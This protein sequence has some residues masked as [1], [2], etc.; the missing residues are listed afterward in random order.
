MRFNIT[1]FVFFICFGVSTYPA[2]SDHGKN[3]HCSSF[4]FRSDQAKA[5]MKTIPKGKHM[6]GIVSELAYQWENK[7][8][9]RSCDAAVAGKTVDFSCLD[10]RRDWNV[11]MSKIPSEIMNQA[12]IKRRPLMLELQAKDTQGKLRNEALDY[13]EDLGVIDLRMKG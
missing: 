7:E 12:D 13:C 4:P 10:G 5:A 2:F 6:R 8:I 11:I 1:T 9:R 3:F